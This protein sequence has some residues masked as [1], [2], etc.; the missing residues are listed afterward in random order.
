M[1]QCISRARQYHSSDS[2]SRHSEQYSESNDGSYSLNRL[3]I[4]LCEVRSARLASPESS[5]LNIPQSSSAL[6]SYTPPRS[7][8]SLSIV[9]P[10]NDSDPTVYSAGRSFPSTSSNSQKKSTPS[11]LSG[12]YINEEFVEVPKKTT[13]KARPDVKKKESPNG[14]EHKEIDFQKTAALEK[15]KKEWRE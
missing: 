4:A 11:P 15:T 5:D 13:K 9:I 2:I 8:R 7:M 10:D 14:I 1:G 12:L 3:S 6:Y